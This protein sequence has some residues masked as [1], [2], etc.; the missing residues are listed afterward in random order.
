MRE[1]ERDHLRRLVGGAIGETERKRLRVGALIG[2]SCVAT[3][4]VACRPERDR[5]GPVTDPPVVEEFLEV[6]AHRPVRHAQ[7]PGD[8][9]VGEPVRGQG[10]DLRLAGRQPAAPK[11]SSAVTALKVA[12]RDPA[13]RFITRSAENSRATL[14]CAYL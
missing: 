8:L 11:V 13:H 4:G 1:V 12:V 7:P 6:R 2:R 10:Q 3:L 14:S 9:L 5:L